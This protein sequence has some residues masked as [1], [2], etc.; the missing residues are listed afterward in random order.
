MKLFAIA[1]TPLICLAQ[2]ITETGRTI[3]AAHCANCH[4]ARADGAR[5]PS[6][7]QM[8]V[9]ATN[10]QGFIEIFL[11][12]IQGTEMPPTRLT[13]G[14]GEAL[15]AY[16]KTLRNQPRLSKTGG[17]PVRG[18][19]LYETKGC[20]N[21]HMISGAGGRMGP[22]L[23]AVGRGRS[24]EYI[25]ESIVDPDAAVPEKFAEYRLVIP[26]PDNYLM[27]KA[28]TTDGRI[29]EG[30]RL[31]EDPF[32]IQIRDFK[33]GLHSFAKSELKELRKQPG[34][35][36]M[37]SFREKLARAEIDDLVAYLL[38]LRGGR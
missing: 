38:T 18:K 34:R 4:G 20:S 1:L 33:D 31:N 3:Y 36:M 2:D 15:L 9:R 5:G 35:S 25:R 26:M 14:E 12:G 17:D 7:R 21:C 32:T 37:P 22:E 11:N 29:I 19:A 8:P 23:T 28:V 16:I 13:Q 30:L 24:A 27:V 10:D 6:L